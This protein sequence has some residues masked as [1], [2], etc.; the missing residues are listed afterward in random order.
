MSES[1]LPQLCN[2][3]SDTAVIENNGVL[4]NGIATLFL[5]DSIVFSENSIVGVIPELSQ[6]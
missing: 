2:D 6:H 4:Q 3:A 1:T 5:G